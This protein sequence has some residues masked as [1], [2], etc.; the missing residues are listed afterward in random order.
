[1]AIGVD[2]LLEIEPLARAGVDEFFCGIISRKKLNGR[3]NNSKFN[4][5]NLSE[6]KRAIEISHFFRK[7][8]FLALNFSFSSDELML[9]EAL[10]LF[11]DAIRL[12]V[13]GIIFADIVFLS[14]TKEKREKIKT[15]ISTLLPKLNSEAINFFKK[16]KADR[17]VLERQTSVKE[18]QNIDKK[19]KNVELEIFAFPVCRYV[20]AFCR[21]REVVGFPHFLPK[22]G[23]P[24]P[25]C[26]I[27]LKMEIISKQERQA[28]E[29]VLSHI[30]NTLFLLDSSIFSETNL[31]RLFYLSKLRNKVVF[32]FDSRGQS[33][34]LKFLQVGALKDII[35]FLS[36]NNPSYKEY[37]RWTKKHFTR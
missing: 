6:L 17:F 11:S 7:E 16:L 5:N 1:M 35:N 19:I 26:V 24:H 21:Y 37:I 12:N 18:I 15:A 23:R 14:K 25:P 36:R 32:K 33:L 9:K 29:Q 2:N 22:D 8:I 27:P 20:N 4:L 30:K 10:S 3:P 31:S 13:D 34:K 28:P